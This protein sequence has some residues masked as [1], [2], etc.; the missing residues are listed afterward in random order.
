MPKRLSDTSDRIYMIGNPRGYGKS[1]LMM[2]V[3]YKRDKICGRKKVPSGPVLF[4][5]FRGIESASDAKSRIMETIR[6]LFIP[7]FFPL[8]DERGSLAFVVHNSIVMTHLFFTFFDNRQ[9]AA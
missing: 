4:T 8:H 6:P 2:E 7:T 3:A 9:A 1:A 5:G